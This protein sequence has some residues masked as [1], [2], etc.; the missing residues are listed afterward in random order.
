MVNVAA[1]DSQLTEASG[2]RD[3][4]DRKGSGW[5]VLQLLFRDFLFI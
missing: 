5:N 2:Y 4:G 3:D 1:S